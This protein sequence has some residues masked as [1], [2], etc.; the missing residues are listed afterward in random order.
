MYIADRSWKFRGAADLALWIEQE[1]RNSLALTVWHMQIFGDWREENRCLTLRPDL[2][3]AWAYGRAVPHIAY[4]LDIRH[5]FRVWRWPKL[6]CVFSLFCERRF[7]QLFQHHCDSEW[8][9]HVYEV[10]MEYLDS[11]MRYLDRLKLS[12]FG[13]GD[14]R[15]TWPDEKEEEEENTLTL[16]SHL[17]FG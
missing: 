17:R 8:K 7:H 16:R 10:K 1:G 6:Y 2:F 3:G 4:L 5:S 11:S 12:C 14:F 15:L 9:K 13:S